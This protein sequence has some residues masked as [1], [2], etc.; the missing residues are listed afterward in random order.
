MGAL[1][2]D[3]PGYP[4]IPHRKHTGHPCGTQQDSPGTT[5]A[6]AQTDFH[7]QREAPNLKK[8]NV[9]FLKE[10]LTSPVPPLRG[11]TGYT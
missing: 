10:R 2:P 6:L 7:N 4:R 11:G 3:T 5:P 1:A 9:F 8:Q